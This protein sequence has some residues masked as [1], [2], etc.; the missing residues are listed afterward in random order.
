MD[1]RAQFIWNAATNVLPLGN[2]ENSAYF[3]QGH[4]LICLLSSLPLFGIDTEKMPISKT[5]MQKN[6]TAYN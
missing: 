2:N 1:L 5:L 4:L 6:G 3:F